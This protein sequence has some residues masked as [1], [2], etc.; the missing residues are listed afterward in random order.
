MNNNPIGIVDSGV[1]GLSVWKELVHLLPR[2]STLFLADQKYVP[3][4]PRSQDEIVRLSTRLVEYLVKK[5]IK[6]I[7]IACNTIS[8]TCLD[9]LRKTFPD[10]PIVGTVPVIKT[11]AILTKKKKIGVLATKR[12]AE[13]EYLTQLIQEHASESNITVVSSKHLVEYIEKGD[14]ESSN[15][16]S[17]LK[18]QLSPFV[19][20][21]CDVVVLGSTHFSFI[22]EPVDRIL[23]QDVTLLD[24]SQA[25]A[26]QVQRI[27]TANDTLSCEKETYEFVTTGDTGQFSRVT[28]LLLGE[29][30]SAIHKEI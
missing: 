18:E 3:Y 10:M 1:G 12:T 28:Q 25:I 16:L 30:L 26:R 11:A 7:V 8:V 14:I 4:G 9:I 2:E 22:R 13:S 24:S 21:G 6:L 5:E 17:V 19:E 29:K 23:G 27:L 15:F 20:T